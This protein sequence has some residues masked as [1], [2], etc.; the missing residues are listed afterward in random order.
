M[1]H[2]QVLKHHYQIKMKKLFIILLMLSGVLTFA[3]KP[4][5]LILKMYKDGK[6]VKRVEG[7]DLD[8]LQDGF[9]IVAK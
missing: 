4:K 3:Q 2:I 7:A 5:Y 6:V 1:N 8:G 9:N